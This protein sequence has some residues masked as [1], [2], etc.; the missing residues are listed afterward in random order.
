MKIQFLGTAAAEG[1]P[2]IFCTCEV[3]QKSR[4]AGGRA[5]RT[6]SQ[7]LIDD[8]VLIDLC[9]DTYFHAVRFHLDFSK[10]QTCF[11]THTHTD[12]LY[13]QELKMLRNGFSHMPEGWCL[14]LF[15][16]QITGEFLLGDEKDDTVRKGIRHGL[17]SFTE[18]R[19]FEPVQAAG[20]TVTPLP[21]LHDPSS[22]PVFYQID[23]GEKTILYAHDTHNFREDVW[24]YWEQ[25][26]PHFDLV[27]LDCT[28][29]CLPLSYVGH[30]GLEENVL[31]KNKMIELG[32][33]DE[34]TVFI[35]NH[36]SHNGTN[37]FY[38]DFMP[39]AAKEGFITSFDGMTIEL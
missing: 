22:G 16:S 28:N 18:V 32:Y 39:I 12:H 9:P 25:T 29:A 36:F 10:I 34:N 5:I 13:M 2:G 11:I 8:K 37:V 24:A 21:A 26:K 27:S 7:A 23:N 6:R 3:C 31:V 17:M 19:P 35:S 33:A 15:G 4:K 38:D 1:V 30:M 14:N 20:Y